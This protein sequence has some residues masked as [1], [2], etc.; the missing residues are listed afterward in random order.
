MMLF[1]EYAGQNL[2][3]YS[4]GYSERKGLRG[5]RVDRDRLG[6]AGETP[7]IPFA[8]VGDSDGHT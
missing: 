7:R 5:S 4:Y 3:R 8:I 1:E 2:L 6:F